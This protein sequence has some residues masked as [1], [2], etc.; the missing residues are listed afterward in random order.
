MHAALNV[1]KT[2][3]AAQDTQL[4]TIANNLANASTVGFKRDRAMFEDLLYQIQRQPGAQSSQET[5]LPSGLQLGTGVRIVG[6]QKQFTE[7]SLQV[8]GQGLD[9]AINGRG[10]FQILMPDGTIGYTRN[11]QFQVD[12][13]G[14]IVNA[15][16]LLLEPNITVPQEASSISISTDGIVSAN[17]FGEP[18]P[19]NLGNIQ[20]VD[21]VNPAGLQSIGG[22]LFLETVASG[23]PIQ[24][25]P[26]ENG[27]GLIEQGVLENSN[28]DIVQEM[29]TMITTQRA[30]EMNSKV[31]LPKWYHPS[32]LHLLFSG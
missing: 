10:F 2:G 25:T 29:V 14:Q 28:V 6:T 27:L 7:G 5:S 32:P 15:N 3:L 12:G 31:I 11:G 20:T 24:G 18:D 16:G 17:I 22:N 26:S 9:L 19:Q 4:T 13:E 30:Y 23:D 8:T 1:S 21:F